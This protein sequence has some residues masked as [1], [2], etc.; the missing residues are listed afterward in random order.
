MFAS[1]CFVWQRPGWCA[2]LRV[3]A[4]V[5][6]ARKQLVEKRSVESKG[7]DFS[8]GTFRADLFI[9][10]TAPADVAPRSRA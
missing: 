9:E 6:A 4:T 3:R 8:L 1:L 7:T 2:R 5:R 10:E